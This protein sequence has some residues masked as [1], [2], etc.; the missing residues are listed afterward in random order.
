MHK[1]VYF[2]IRNNIIFFHF[3]EPLRIGSSH[4]RSPRPF[5][6]IGE[7]APA[8]AQHG[9]PG[10][11]EGHGAPPAPQLSYS[12]PP[13]PQHSYGGDSQP[14]LVHSQYNTPAQMYSGQ[15]IEDSY[16]AHAQG[17]S[18]ELSGYVNT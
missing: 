3:K 12:S 4:N 18:S 9:S 6:G 8:P 7:C 17:L 1:H 10:G 2:E 14:L 13:A 5:P 11:S 15:S 16:G